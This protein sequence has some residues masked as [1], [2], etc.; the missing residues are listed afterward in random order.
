MAEHTIE[1]A[2]KLGTLKICV[3]YSVTARMDGVF[4]IVAP[5]DCWPA[6]DKPGVWLGNDC[7]LDM[8]EDD[9]E[10]VMKAIE[11]SQ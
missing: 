2:H 3:G 7:C 1:I 4:V 5:K 8:T 10:R 6:V 11:S 9:V